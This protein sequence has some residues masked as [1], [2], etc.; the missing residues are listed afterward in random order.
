MKSGLLAAVVVVFGV[1][2]ARTSEVGAEEKKRSQLHLEDL[3]ETVSRDPFVIRGESCPDYREEGER[4]GLPQFVFRSLPGGCD[5][6]Y[7]GWLPELLRF[8]R[9]EDRD[10]GDFGGKLGKLGLRMLVGLGLDLA[11]NFLDRSGRSLGFLKDQKRF[12]FDLQLG[13]DH[14]GKIGG[15]FTFSF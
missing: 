12:R 14:G 13:F 10:F 2:L 1:F 4:V 3:D 5:D 8:T 7:R 6:Y 15:K 9:D 11:N